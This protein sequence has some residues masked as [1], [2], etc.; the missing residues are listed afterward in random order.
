MR[1]IAPPL[2]AGVGTFEDDEQAGTDLA[3]PELAA[4][5]EAQLEQPSL[6]RLDA[7]LVLAAPQPL[8]EVELVESSRRAH[9]LRG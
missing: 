7:P 1:L 4:E 9:Q 5:M 3:G 6:G 8:G 2:P